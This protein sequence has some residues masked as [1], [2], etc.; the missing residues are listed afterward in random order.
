ML[1]SPESNVGW[2]NQQSRGTEVSFV[3]LTPQ[4]LSPDEWQDRFPASEMTAS[5]DAALRNTTAV[6]IG[7]SCW[8]AAE[9]SSAVSSTNT[10]GNVDG[11][12]RP[13]A[14][15]SLLDDAVITRYL[16]HM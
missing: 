4:L 3:L 9:R 2:P 7:D 16:N 1:M 12:Q 5:K 8:M 13:S 15:R 6:R 11:K 14:K 10:N